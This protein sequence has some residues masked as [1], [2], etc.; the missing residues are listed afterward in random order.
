MVDM[1]LKLKAGA[2]VVAEKTSS[3]GGKKEVAE[4]LA[5][6]ARTLA[7][8]TVVPMVAT[9]MSRAIPEWRLATMGAAL[10]AILEAE[11]TLQVGTMM[12][13]VGEVKT[14]LLVTT[15]FVAMA[16]LV[17]PMTAEM[18]TARKVLTMVAAL[19][20]AGDHSPAQPGKTSCFS[21]APR[22]VTDTRESAK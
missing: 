16:P 21:G 12:A 7:V 19:V 18:N 3:Q 14:A 2:L 13:E 8:K 20:V 17:P 15:L 1:G 6:L 4:E 22:Q 9:E 11:M 10:A 5:M